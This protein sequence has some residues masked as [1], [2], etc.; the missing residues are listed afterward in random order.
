MANWG[1]AMSAGS[2]ADPII[3]WCGQWMAA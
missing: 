2:T 3:R 1:G